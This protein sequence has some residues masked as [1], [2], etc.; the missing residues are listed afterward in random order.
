MCGNYRSSFL[1]A[2]FNICD[3]NYGRI[4]YYYT[5]GE[6]VSNSQHK[7]EPEKKN[8]VGNVGV[9]GELVYKHHQNN[10]VK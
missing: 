2:I 10:E 7:H 9:D 5:D 6:T 1:H 8:I 3:H 4:S